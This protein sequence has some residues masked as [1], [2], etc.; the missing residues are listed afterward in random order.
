MEEWPNLVESHLTGI[1]VYENEQR[2]EI[3]L[4]LLSGQK[5][6]IVLEGVDRFFLNGM[7]ERNIIES[8]HLRGQ[9][10]TEG[11]FE[12]A[13]AWLVTGIPDGAFDESFR[14]IVEDSIMKIRN[15]ELV[16]FEICPIYGVEVVALSRVVEFR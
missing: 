6:E 3:F 2:V 13:V 10:E 11:D 5:H 4:T 15:G 16:L 14:P 1:L 7:R 9:L 12:S 8:V